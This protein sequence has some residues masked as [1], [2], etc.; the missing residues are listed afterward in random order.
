MNKPDPIFV[1]FCLRNVKYML[2][3]DVRSL[4][5]VRKNMITYKKLHIECECYGRT[6]KVQVHHI[7][8][9]SVRP[10]LAADPRNF[11]S[12]CG[13]PHCHLIDGHGGNFK[14]YVPNVR[15]VCELKQIRRRKDFQAELP[16]LPSLSPA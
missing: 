13:K 7:L 15:E 8:P 2:N 11:I 5:A 9:V 4:P 6:K 12:L 1:T 3:E 16:L 10:D 14:D